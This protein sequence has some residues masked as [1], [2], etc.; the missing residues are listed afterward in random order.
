MSGI[1]FA[2]IFSHSLGCPLILLMVS[3]AVSKLLVWYSPICLFLLFLPLLLTSSPKKKNTP[4][5]QN[6][7]AYGLCFLLV[8]W[9]Q[10]LG[11]LIYFELIFIYSVKQNSSFILSHVA[12]QFTQHNLLKRESFFCCVVVP[13]YLQGIQLKT[14]SG[15]LKPWIIPNSN[16]HSLEIIYA[17]CQATTIKWKSQ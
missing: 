16:R 10:V 15:Y 11:S 9:L 13:P 4:Q 17:Q 2:S 12:V 14:L 7:G 5:D 3:F 1:W 6:R 8:L